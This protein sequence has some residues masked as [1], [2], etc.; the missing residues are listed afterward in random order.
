MSQGPSVEGFQDALL[1]DDPV[2]LYENAPC[3][4]LSTTPDGTITKVNA[5]FAAWSGFRTDALIGKPF[6]DLLPVGSRIYYETH[7]APLLRMQASVQEI[8]LDIVRPNGERLPVLLNARLDRDEDQRPRVVRVAIFDAT[9]R[10]SYERELLR[11]K[12]HAE[13]AE[14]QAQALARTLQETLIPPHP[15]SVPGLDVAAAYRPAG[16]GTEVGGDFYDVFAV[17]DG[18]WMVVV[19][20]VCGKGAEAAVVTAL[21]RYTVRTLAVTLESPSHVLAKLDEAI[22][23]HAS[24]RFCTMVIARLRRED[25]RWVATISSGGHPPPILVRR[26]QAPEEIS[27]QG[28]LLGLIRDASYTDLRIELGPGDAMLF[29]TDGVTEARRGRTM[30]GAE[31]LLISVATQVSRSDPESAAERI[32]SGILAEVLAF[33]SGLARDDIAEVAISVP[34]NW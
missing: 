18:E 15:P 27:T 33:Q 2:Q 4:Y 31:R 21:A 7:V 34:L 13:A 23:R 20:D 30:F 29:Y 28:S 19:G 9:E 6:T 12:Q 10:R 14:Q 11:A 5:T 16:D 22:K 3:G 24:D 25:D 32:V 8:A 17:G 26:G 1:E